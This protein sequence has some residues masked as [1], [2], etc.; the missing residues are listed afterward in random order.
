MRFSLKA[1]AARR[2]PGR[3]WWLVA[4]LVVLVVAGLAV[5][6]YVYN[7]DLKPVSSSQMTQIFVVEKGSSVKQIAAKLEEAKLIRSAWAFQLYVHGKDLTNKLQA[8]T[9]ALSPGQSTQE[10][11]AIISKGQVA[12]RLVTI[13]PGRR[14][15]Q[16][17]ADL[18]NTRGSR[19]RA[20]SWS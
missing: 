13:L 15:D 7:R 18:I 19:S 2:R 16:V 20:S 12:S 14:I 9:Y 4:I 6:R 5:S 10:I 8:G 17:R 3:L 1:K 11:A